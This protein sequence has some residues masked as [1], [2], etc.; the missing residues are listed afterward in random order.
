MRGFRYLSGVRNLKTFFYRFTG[1]C[2]LL[3]SVKSVSNCCARCHLD[4]IIFT[5]VCSSVTEVYIIEITQT[6]IMYCNPM[7]NV[8]GFWGRGEWVIHSRNVVSQHMVSPDSLNPIW[9]NKGGQVRSGSPSTK[10]VLRWPEKEMILSS[11]HPLHLSARLTIQRT[12][13]RHAHKHCITCICTQHLVL[14]TL[15]CKRF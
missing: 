15:S 12:Q 7:L 8:W 10:I 14:G 6:H 2:E 13:H 5:Y 11:S 9:T 4:I 1:R 3:T